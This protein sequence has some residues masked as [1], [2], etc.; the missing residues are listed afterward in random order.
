MKRG[1]AIETNELARRLDRQLDGERV[2]TVALT[3]IGTAQTAI[4]CE[5]ERDLESGDER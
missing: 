4:V 1:S 3:R 2:L 5:R